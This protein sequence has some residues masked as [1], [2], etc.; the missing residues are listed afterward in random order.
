MTNAGRIE[1]RPELGDGP[2]PAI[3]DI[4]RAARL[5]KVVGWTTA[6][7]AAAYVVAMGSRRG[8]GAQR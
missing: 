4:R 3:A 2:R 7:A 1:E 8:R 5:S 6:V